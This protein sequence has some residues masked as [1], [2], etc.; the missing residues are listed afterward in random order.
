MEAALW[1]GL[2]FHFLHFLVLPKMQVD[3]KGPLSSYEPGPLKRFCAPRHQISAKS[4][5]KKRVIATKLDL[6]QNCVN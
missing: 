2:L 4:A 1:W 3:G 5:P 6:W